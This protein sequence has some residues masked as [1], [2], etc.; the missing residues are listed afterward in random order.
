MVARPNAITVKINALFFMVPSLSDEIIG[1]HYKGTGQALGKVARF[2]GVLLEYQSVS[3]SWF[4]AQV[5]PLH[6]LPKKHLLKNII[7]LKL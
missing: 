4:P 1:N 3:Y 5:G 6:N 7:S 2:P